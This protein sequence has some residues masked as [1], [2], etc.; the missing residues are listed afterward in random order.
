MYEIDVPAGLKRIV[1]ADIKGFSSFEQE[2]EILFDLDSSFKL[3]GIV[4]DE[5][6]EDRWIIRLQASD[7]GAILAD[8]YVAD[9]NREL[10]QSSAEILFGKLLID[11]GDPD[12]AIKYFQKLLIQSKENEKGKCKHQSN[13]I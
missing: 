12:E 8:K 13:R 2:E 1:C 11:M 4:R 10:K 6:K 3:I 9:S 5:E 7:D